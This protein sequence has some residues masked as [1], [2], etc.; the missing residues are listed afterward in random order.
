MADPAYRA[1]AEAALAVAKRRADLLEKIRSALLENEDR[2]A[3]R[4]MRVY[5]GIDEGKND[6]EEDDRIDSSLH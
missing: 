5:V 3:L 1:L 2:R 6:E 4:L